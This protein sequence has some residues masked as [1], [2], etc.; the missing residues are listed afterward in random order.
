MELE[1]AG[2]P[3]CGKPPKIKHN[4]G[5]PKLWI[6]TCYNIHCNISLAT[7]PF[8]TKEAAIRVWNKRK[9]ESK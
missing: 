5:N 7:E 9:E 3:F 4:W 1:P 2:C 6:V 8:K